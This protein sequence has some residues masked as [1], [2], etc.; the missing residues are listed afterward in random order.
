MAS[1]WIHLTD[2]ER[3]TI[4]ASLSTVASAESIVKKLQRS[5]TTIKT[6]SAKS[7]GRNL[8]YW[9]A[10]RIAQLLGMQFN[11]HDDSC[12]IHS[13]EMGQSGADV[14]LR[15]EAKKKFPFVV[16]CKSCENISFHAFVEQARKYAD[17]ENWLLVIRTKSLP[18]TTVTMAWG[19]FETLF[20]K[21]IAK[22]G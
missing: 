8:Q 19:T 16:E 14:I 6:S 18:V 21:S 9:V 3:N 13:R 20:S 12:E 22:D 17:E 11:Q 2:K 4:V 15:G 10:E 5:E 7:K 1:R